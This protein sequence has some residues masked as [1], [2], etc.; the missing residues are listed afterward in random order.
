MACDAHRSC[1]IDHTESKSFT[2]SS[3]ASATLFEWIDGGFSVEESIETGNDY[4]CDGNPNDFFSV[5]KNQGQT[6][7]TVQN[8]NLNQCTGSSDVGGS[9]FC[10]P[11]T[12]T[13]LMAFST[14]CMVS[15]IVAA[16][17]QAGWTRAAGQEALDRVS[18]LLLG[19]RARVSGLCRSQCCCLGVTKSSCLRS[20]IIS[21]PGLFHVDTGSTS[22][23]SSVCRFRPTSSEDVLS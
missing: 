11:P 12:S 1:S 20:F 9:L 4:H 7:Y 17:A 13:T 22:V 23:F 19:C 15:S 10:G 5:W 2:I 14:A 18:N 8:A 21:G 3:S 6:A 16:R